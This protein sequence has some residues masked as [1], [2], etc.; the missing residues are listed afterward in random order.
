MSEI[1]IY[2]QVNCK[3]LVHNKWKHS[4]NNIHLAHPV[5]TLMLHFSQS[6]IDQTRDML[7]KGE[8]LDLKMMT[9][10]C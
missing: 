9:L 2:E 7:I 10:P 8:R 3:T 4:I 5:Q 6:L 1:V